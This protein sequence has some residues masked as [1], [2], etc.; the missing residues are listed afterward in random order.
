MR[1]ARVAVQERVG[2]DEHAAVA[3][4][5]HRWHHAVMQGRRI[6]KD[7]KP[8]HQRH[9][10]PDR[11]SET[12]EQRQAVEQ[13]VLVGEIRDSQHLPDICKNV[14]VR[15]FDALGHAFGTARENNDGGG[16]GRE[17]GIERRYA[18]ENMLQQRKKFL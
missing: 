18:G 15:Q 1:L 4:V 8:A 9:E 12:V 16:T 6:K 3:V 10:R 11:E 14:S 13:A 2:A 17:L 7:I 5:K